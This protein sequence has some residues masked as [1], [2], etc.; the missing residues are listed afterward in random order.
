[1]SVF[2]TISE[3]FIGFTPL[4]LAITGVVGMLWIAHWAMLGRHPEFGSERRLF[5]QVLLLVLTLFGILVVILALP[6]PDDTRNQIIALVGVLLSGVLAFSSTTVFSNLVAGLMLRVTKPFVTGDFIRVGDY[7]GRV[8]E[9]GLLDTEI[10]TETRDLITL[11]NM[12]LITNPVSTTRSSGVIISATVSLGYEINHTRI[13]TLLINAAKLAELQ[14]PFVHILELGD[15]SV[16]Y[17]V[18]GL[19]PEIKSLLTKRS[20]L[21]QKILDVLH[22]DGISIVSP[23]FMNQRQFDKSD[24]FIPGKA[25]TGGEQSVKAEEIVFDKA[26]KAEREDRSEQQIIARLAELKNILKESKTV[27][28]EKIMKEIERQQKRLELLK[29]SQENKT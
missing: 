21:C 27:A 24:S 29:K 18:S 28:K 4:L 23:A 20:E 6:V 15:F 26:E 10:Q 2:R 1:M 25:K 5:R 8:V 12:Y 19:L 9:R 16:S 13:E 7:F 14:E 22:E 17:R 3:W 11:S